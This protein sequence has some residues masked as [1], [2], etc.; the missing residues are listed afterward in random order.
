MS[1]SIPLFKVFTAADAGQAVTEVLQSGYIGQGPKVDAFEA[2]LSNKLQS[3]YISALNSA[4]SGLHLA[5]HM[6]RGGPQ[7]EI[8]T[9]PLTCTATNFPIVANGF[10]IKWVDLC[11]LTCNMSLK[12]LRR[13]LSPKTAAIMVV[14]WGGCPIDLD[15]L[16]KIQDECWRLYGHRP[17]IIEDCAHAFGSTYKGK[18]IGSHGNFS[19]FSFQAI[20]HLTTGDGGALICPDDQTH[21]RAKLLRWY[22]LDRTSSADFRCE[23][24]IEEWGFKF[25]MND[26]AAAIGLKNFDHIDSI[27]ESHIKNAAY[28]RNELHLANGITLLK[29]PDETVSASWIFTLLTHDRRD[30]FMKYM[31]S[32]GIGV[33]RVHDRN[34]KHTCLA[35]FK[36]VLPDTDYVCSHMCCIPCGWWLTDEDRG[37]IVDCIKKGW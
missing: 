14:H 17:P 21:R 26:I 32:C 5:L 22:G 19:V 16:R 10:K 11:W 25:H 28:L 18:P 29:E 31:K 2:A 3:P 23:Q 12:D 33:S 7:D 13:K 4:T 1:R 34:D 36:S 30:D 8:L 15:E 27:I 20:K 35:E 9:T 6:L 24:N 37:Y